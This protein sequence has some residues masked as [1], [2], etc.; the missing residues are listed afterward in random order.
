VLFLLQTGCQKS[1]AGTTGI[2]QEPVAIGGQAYLSIC[3]TTNNNG[4]DS[5]NGITMH[6]ATFDPDTH[7]VRE[8]K[9]EIPYY[10]QYPLAVYSDIDHSVYFAKRVEDGDRHGDNLFVCNL[11]TNETTQ[12]TDS[13]S[14]IN[15]IIPLQN[16]VILSASPLG[17]RVQLLIIYDKQ[18]RNLREVLLL[19]NRE[20][21]CIAFLNYNAYTEQL[22]AAVYSMDERDQ[23]DDKFNTDQSITE[24]TRGVPATHSLFRLSTQDFVPHKLLECK[25]TEITRAALDSNNNVLLTE[26]KGLISTPDADPYNNP[27]TLSLPD[28]TT[29]LYDPVS[30]KKTEAGSLEDVFIINS[31]F[32]SFHSNQNEVFFIG[33]GKDDETKYP[34][35]IYSYN[36]DTETLE[37]LFVNEDG[38]I[39]N[40]YLLKPGEDFS[41]QTGR[42]T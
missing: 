22:L 42:I 26:N 33:V 2:P 36:Y 35:G 15:E 17:G 9:S 3:I 29:F 25:D 4:R 13:L 19:G 32:L 21:E 12:L 39:N 11:N 1:G 14:T 20:D 6:S 28:I 38:W 23:K 40:F 16:F 30:D 34:R 10:A 7:H 37:Q 27:P 31:T 5:E 41:G 18:S 8:I 24:P